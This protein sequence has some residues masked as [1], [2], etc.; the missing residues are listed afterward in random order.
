MQLLTTA[1]ILC[2]SGT[3]LNDP[4]NVKKKKNAKMNKDMKWP[5]PT[6]H[7]STITMAGTTIL[8][9]TLRVIFWGQ[10][11]FDVCLFTHSQAKK[12]VT[13]TNGEVRKLLLNEAL[14]KKIKY[15]ILWQEP[16]FSRAQKEMNLTLAH[17]SFPH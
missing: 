13:Q 1:L 16:C 2:K 8:T 3:K 6:S 10:L 12:A 15:C 9:R 11:W 4:W 7:N 14:W 5:Q 17:Y